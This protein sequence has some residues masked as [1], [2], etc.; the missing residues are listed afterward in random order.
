MINDAIPGDEQYKF[1]ERSQNLLTKWAAALGLSTP[2]T[3]TT[4]PGD[5]TDDVP[6]TT[7]ETNGGD[8]S[9]MTEADTSMAAAPVAEPDTKT[10]GAEPVATDEAPAEEAPASAAETAA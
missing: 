3:A 8:T 10:N 2:V 7:D 1:K 9:M 4:V 5:K 6:A